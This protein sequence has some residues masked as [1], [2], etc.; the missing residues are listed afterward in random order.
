MPP[1]H[2][3]DASSLV[4][5]IMAGG[6]G[7]RF[8]P[9]STADRPKQLLDLERSGRTLLQAMFDRLVPLAG[10]PERVFVATGS[11]YVALVREQ[12][13]DLP[14]DN[15]IVEPTGH[16]SAAAV[17]L[18]SL[19]MHERT[20][21]ATLGFFA[22][23][24]RIEGEGAFHTAPHASGVIFAVSAPDADRR[25]VENGIQLLQRVGVKIFGT[26]A[27][28][29]PPGKRGTGGY[30]YGYGAGYGAAEA[31]SGP[32]E[33]PGRSHAAVARRRPTGEVHEAD[34]RFE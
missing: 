6:R 22:S 20:G 25:S 29:T 15:G 33:K 31:P 9:P 7:Q 28:N 11:R 10:A 24:H 2:T 18:A 17:G 30:G 1:E 5:V 14:A 13:P 26:V 19:T 8:W 4:P 16:D 12:L 32:A 27:A 23:D 21:G 34:L 3:Q